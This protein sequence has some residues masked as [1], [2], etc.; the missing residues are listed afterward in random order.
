LELIYLKVTQTK[1]LNKSTKEFLLLCK[2]NQAM[3]INKKKKKFNLIAMNLMIIIIKM[4]VIIVKSLNSKIN[5]F[6][7]F[8]LLFSGW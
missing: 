4:S 6:L 7:Q 1:L 2:N 5:Y 3:L 8:I